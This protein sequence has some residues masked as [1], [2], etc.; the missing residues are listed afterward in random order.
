MPGISN[1]SAFI[2]SI[3]GV[4]MSDDL[5]KTMPFDTFYQRMIDGAETST[6]QINADEYEAYWE[7]FLKDGKD[8]LHVTLSSGI[9]GSYNSRCH[10]V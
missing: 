6:S 1:T 3:D 2:I 4:Q 8:V 10:R 5:G 7:S 9:S